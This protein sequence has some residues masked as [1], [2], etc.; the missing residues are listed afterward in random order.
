MKSWIT[1]NGFRIFQV[2]NG[3]SNSYL[4]STENSNV[5][6]DTGTQSA[7]NKLLSNIESL[8]LKTGGI[9]LLIL[10]HNHFDHSGNAFEVQRKY[11]CRIVL[12]KRELDFAKLGFSKLP[13]GTILI[14]KF[15]SYIGNIFG[16][17]LFDFKPFVPD[18]VIDKELDLGEYGFDIKVISTNGHS[19]G[20][21]S[22]IVD[23]EIA[24][25]GDTLF[26]IFKNSVFPPYSD[27]IKRM[28]ESWGELLQTDCQ[29][30]LPGHGTEI[31]RS[32]LLKE[33]IRFS[34]KILNS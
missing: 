5:L 21:I 30:F 25:V 18:I 19:T 22:V 9:D 4:I 2:L 20:S 1:K 27:D 32:L 33:F 34:K 24:I 14:T 10:T 16:S 13:R 3:R 15:I 8:N 6:V 11:S 12:S 17:S 26:G 28:I 29:I 31:K 23:N 7:Y